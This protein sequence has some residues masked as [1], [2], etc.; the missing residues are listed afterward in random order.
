MEKRKETSEDVRGVY[1]S[2][3]GDVMIKEFAIKKK[4]H[5]QVP[6]VV[7]TLPI[8]CPLPVTTGGDG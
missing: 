5:K 2:K 6:Q 8:S 4:L 7:H 3:A 1:P